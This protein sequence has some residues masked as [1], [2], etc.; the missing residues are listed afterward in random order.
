M[1]LLFFARRAQDPDLVDDD[2]G[3]CG[4]LEFMCC[5]V[6]ACCA[7]ANYVPPVKTDAPAAPTDFKNFH[8]RTRRALAQ[9]IAPVAQPVADTAAVA[10]VP[11]QV[12]QVMAPAPPGAVVAQAIA[13]VV[14]VA[15][16]PPPPP[17]MMTVQVPAGM[18]PGSMMQVQVPQGYACAGQLMQFAV[19]AG[20]APG[21]MMQV[22]LPQ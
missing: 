22:A 21:G 3:L 15:V 13:P 14:A 16:A 12:A 19:P 5:S 4:P 8:T 1:T 9:A 2:S 11:A 18:L 7:S 20:L 17:P 10:A 6:S